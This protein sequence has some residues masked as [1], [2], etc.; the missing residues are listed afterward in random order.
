MIEIVS[1]STSVRSGA[2]ALPNAVF[3]GLRDVN[4]PDDEVVCS[5]S[6]ETEFTEALDALLARAVMRPQCV[7]SGALA[8]VMVDS[9]DRLQRLPQAQVFACQEAE[10]LIYYLCEPGATRATSRFARIIIDWHD[11]EGCQV[12]ASNWE[13]WETFEDGAVNR[14]G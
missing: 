6:L 5:P 12:W 11:E 9:Q 13:D 4:F 8:S 14:N 7:A 1:A 3:A 2:D 10:P